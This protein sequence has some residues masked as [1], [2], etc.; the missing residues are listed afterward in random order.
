MGTYLNYQSAPVVGRPSSNGT[1]PISNFLGRGP[2]SAQLKKNADGSFMS[3][4]SVDWVDND[5][6]R[7][8]DPIDIN[9]HCFDPGTTFALNPKAWTDPAAGT[10]GTAA[11][12]YN[13]YRHNAWLHNDRDMVRTLRQWLLEGGL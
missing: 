10:F 1:L 3:P 9:C 2:G 4:W 7:R 11:A 5:G 6:N 12:Y 8:P 13:D